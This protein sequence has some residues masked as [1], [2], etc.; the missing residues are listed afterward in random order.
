MGQRPLFRPRHR[1]GR[2]QELGDFG[3]FDPSKLE[4]EDPEGED[5]ER[6]WPPSSGGRDV[7]LTGLME[8]TLGNCCGNAVLVVV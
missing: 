5:P 7:T 8:R 2:I 1:I 4:A 6:S 3:D